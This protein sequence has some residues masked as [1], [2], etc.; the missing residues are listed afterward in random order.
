[1]RRDVAG[2]GGR[3]LDGLDVG[4]VAAVVAG[5]V[6]V[7]AGGR[8]G[9]ELLGGRAAHGAG[10]RR[11]DLVVD[12]QALEDADVGVAVLRVG[13]L[14]AVVVQVEGVR[15]LHEELAAAQDAGA[16]ARLVAVLGLDLVQRD[17]QVLVG[18]DLA[19]H[20]VGEHLL[21]GGA[22][23][24]VVAAAV[25]EAEQVVA[26]LGPAAG[27]LVVVAGQQR[28]EL[29][30]LRAHRV[31]LLADDARDVLQHGLAQRQPAVDAG[32][33]PADVA[34]AHQELVARDLGVR[35]V[36]AQGPEE[37]RRHTPDHGSAPLTCGELRKR[38]QGQRYPPSG[39]SLFDYHSP[40]TESRATVGLH[41]AED[42]F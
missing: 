18:G 32:R 37:Q 12:A 34:A 8:G 27:R 20:H 9:Q 33:D 5:H 15:V 19:L 1:M 10:H 3:G 16:G 31:H 38:R 42:S 41:G 2:R 6:G 35:R 14:Q 26:V 4:G 29:D 22:Q 24:V 17:R 21:V 25:L 11:D 23:E 39:R 30:L 36:L 13:L 7:L 40:T 28:G